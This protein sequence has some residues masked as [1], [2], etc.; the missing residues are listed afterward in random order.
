[1]IFLVAVLPAHILLRGD[2][3]GGV[4]VAVFLVISAEQAR[5]PHC[6]S[7][8]YWK[9]FVSY[10]EAMIRASVIAVINRV[11]SYVCRKV[12]SFFL[13]GGDGGVAE[14][15]LQQEIIHA[16]HCKVVGNQKGF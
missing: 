16:W 9:T 1:M 12:F 13:G 2:G 14:Y 11:C 3:A 4:A 15:M 6:C 10:F 8:V 7:F 5:R